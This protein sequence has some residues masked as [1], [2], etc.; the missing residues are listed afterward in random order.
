M[1]LVRAFTAMCLDSAI[2]ILNHQLVTPKLQFYDI[3]NE[4]EIC[5]QIF[6]IG[7]VSQSRMSQ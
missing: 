2:Y 5:D 1:S 4:K 6:S 7:M 3:Y